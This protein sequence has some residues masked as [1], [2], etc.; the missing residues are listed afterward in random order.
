MKQAVELV[1]SLGLDPVVYPE[2]KLDRVA[3][4]RN[5]IS[6]SRTRARYRS[7]PPRLNPEGP[8][9]Q[10]VRPC[11]QATVGCLLVL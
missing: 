5:P 9:T 11:L 10:T 7:E 4:V 2:G 8:P 3:Q 6:L 1:K